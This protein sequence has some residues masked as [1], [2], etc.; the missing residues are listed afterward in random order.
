MSDVLV[1]DDPAAPPSPGPE[2]HR[3]DRTAVAAAVAALVVTAVRWWT[4][5]GRRE[6]AIWPDEP[7]QLAIARFVGG[8]ARWNMYDHSVWRPL[9][10]TLISS[11]YRFTDDPETVFRFGLALN[12]VLGGVAAALLVF[13]TRR[14]TP[15]SAP[16]CAGLAL[17]ASLAPGALF[18]TDFVF[19]E[20]L[21]VPLYLATLLGLFAFHE[22][23]SLRLGVG[24]GLTSAAAFA[25]HARMLPLALVVI[26]TAALA[27]L[28]H[29]LAGRAVIAVVVTTVGA[30][31]VASAYTGYV[32]DHLWRDPS[33]RNSLGGVV[34]QLGN[35]SAVL[36]SALGQ[37]WYLLVATVGVTAYGAVVL[38][39][40]ALGRSGSDL[41]RAR[42]ARVLLVTVGSCVALSVLFMSD[43]WRSDQLVYGRYNDAVMGPVLVVGLA[44]LVG[45]VPLRRFPTLVAGTLCA[46]VAGGS[47]LW[48]LRH[49]VL[50]ESNGVEPM[51]LGLQPF[52][53]SATSIDVIRITVRA[54][55]VAGI[56]GATAILARRRRSAA[57]RPA[58]VVSLLVLGLVAVGWVRTRTI[59]DGRWHDSGNGGAVAE[60]R[61]GPLVDG[62]PVD[63]HVPFGS[64]STGRMMLY[65]FH[66]PRTEFTVVH[67]ERQVG[68]SPLVFAAVDS[69]VLEQSG[70]TLVWRDPL[71]EYGL[72]D[73]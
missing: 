11:A 65:Q 38:V 9:F 40:S 67:D 19:A 60:L 36:V 7:A 5:H 68:S 13:V 66:L 27:G 57:L 8:G 42:D 62:V 20:S 44:A 30:S 2:P 21:V 18:T 52:S 72:W 28:R 56:L 48:W 43:R 25:T 54:A 17:V 26:G 16:W 6:Y 61:T 33:N 53:T 39:R 3:A 14:L 34:G 37:V 46:L 35:G 73:R 55:I 4:S 64:T 58:V 69:D 71:G 1:A 49:P 10:G 41:P 15:A 24:I 45:V 31:L 23:P 59:V 50:S 63:F 70:A 51:I 12:A 32:V 47:L 22:S 29:R